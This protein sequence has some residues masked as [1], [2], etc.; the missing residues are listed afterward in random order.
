MNNENTGK[1]PFLKMGSASEKLTDEDKESLTRFLGGFRNLQLAAD[2]IP[3]NR[4]TLFG[5]I[6]GGSGHPD[7]IKKIREAINIPA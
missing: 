3:M 1:S 2:A 5:I 7:N 6:K 4:I